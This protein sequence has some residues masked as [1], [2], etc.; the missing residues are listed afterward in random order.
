MCGHCQGHSDSEDQEMSTTFPEGHT[1]MESR[2]HHRCRCSSDRHAHEEVTS[3][4][5][6][7]TRLDQR[8]DLASSDIDEHK[9]KSSTET[10]PSLYCHIPQRSDGCSH[11]PS[12]NHSLTDDIDS[13]NTLAYSLDSGKEEERDKEHP[14][15]S[16][17]LRRR[18]NL[19]SRHGSLP[20]RSVCLFTL[21]TCLLCLTGSSQARPSSTEERVRK[22]HSDTVVSTG[23]TRRGFDTFLFIKC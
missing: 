1:E 18:G 6:I 2:L 7:T 10:S 20:T 11:T 16:Q 22:V 9:L 8:C 13:L 21:A 19:T 23:Y 4:T 3:C 15:I 17:T 5:H 14:S 12:F